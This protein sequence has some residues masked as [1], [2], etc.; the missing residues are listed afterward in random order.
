[1]LKVFAAVLGTFALLWATLYVWGNCTEAGQ[2][3]HCLDS[4]GRWDY[5]LKKCEGA[6]PGYD[7]P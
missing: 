7:V 3:D 1:M 4:S 6:R 2:I 5:A